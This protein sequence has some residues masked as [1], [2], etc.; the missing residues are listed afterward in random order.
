MFFI[1]SHTFPKYLKLVEIAMVHVLI[2][3]E[4]K[5]CFNSISF[6]KSKM[7][8]RLNPHSQL[9]GPMYAQLFFTL[10]TFPY[11]TTLESWAS[12]TTTS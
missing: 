2:F 3:I 11:A 1:L 4:D 5:R 9:V 12:V 10:D 8:N 6:L 7:W